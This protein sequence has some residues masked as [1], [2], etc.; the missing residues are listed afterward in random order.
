[1]SLGSSGPA[2][3]APSRSSATRPASPP[4]AAT[5]SGAKGASG[6]RVGAWSSRPTCPSGS[7]TRSGTW[8]T[9]RP[10]A[11]YF[12]PAL[13]RVDPSPRCA[14]DARSCASVR[15]SSAILFFPFLSFGGCFRAPLDE[16]FRVSGCSARA[17]DICLTHLLSPLNELQSCTLRN[18]R[19]PDFIDVSVSKSRSFPATLSEIMPGSEDSILRNP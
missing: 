11:P 15:L 17:E 4:A 6:A 9:E 18:F 3:T 1:M 10:K 16:T 14:G 7:T 12:A 8:G 19:Q 2:R 5:T 13:H